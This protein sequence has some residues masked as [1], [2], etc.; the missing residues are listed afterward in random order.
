[1]LDFST[2]RISPDGRQAALTLLDGVERGIWVLDLERGSLHPVT[3]RGWNSLPNWSPDGKTLTYYALRGDGQGLS[4]RRADGGGE[5]ERLLVRPTRPFPRHWS[6][7]GRRLVFW[8]ASRTWQYMDGEVTQLDL[9]PP[10]ARSFR[11]SPD[12]QLVAF[13]GQEGESYQVFVQRFPGPG[14][15]V[16]VSGGTDEVSG[17]PSESRSPNWRADGKE[18]YYSSNGAVFAVE[19]ETEPE[20]RVAPPRRLFEG[21]YWLD[22]DATPDG[23]RFLMRSLGAASA[24]RELQVV[25]NWFEEIEHLVPHPRH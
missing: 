18:L 4:R 20:L 23:E 25:L 8:E 19:V 13:E 24:A 6:P 14:P 12:G 11:F 10:G 16:Q 21:D 22:F 5:E 7:D 3:T 1:M 15:R 2:V 9:E 17:E